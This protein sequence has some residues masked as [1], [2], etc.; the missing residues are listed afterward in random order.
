[1]SKGRSLVAGLLVGGVIG[2]VTALLTTPTSGKNFRKQ[3][4]TNCGKFQDTVNKLKNDGVALKEQVIKTAQEGA[5]IIKDVGS[6]LQSSIQ[7]WKEAIKPHQQDLKK[8]IAEIEDKI[9]Q[10]EK[11]LQN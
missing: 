11:T 1:M 8:E 9:K 10:L 6:E 4:K 7:E 5:E 3:L 2:G